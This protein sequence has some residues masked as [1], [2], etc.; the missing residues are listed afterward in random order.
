MLPVGGQSPAFAAVIEFADFVER[1]QIV[2]E[3]LVVLPGQLVQLAVQQ[4]EAFAEQVVVQFFCDDRPAGGEFDPAYRRTSLEAGAFV[5]RA[6]VP[7]QALRIRVGVVRILPEHLVSVQYGRFCGQDGKFAGAA[8]AVAVAVGGDS[9]NDPSGGVFPVGGI[10]VTRRVERRHAAAADRQNDAI[11]FRAEFRYDPLRFPLRDVGAVQRRYAAYQ[12][13][14]F[15]FRLFP[16]LFRNAVGFRSS[17][18][19][20]C[21]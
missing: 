7:Q 17:G 3:R 11:D 18:S 5:Q 1:F 15:L 19:Y 16:F 13:G 6:V 20:A 14:F 21:A 9:V 2:D 4:R 12:A 10:H 8:V